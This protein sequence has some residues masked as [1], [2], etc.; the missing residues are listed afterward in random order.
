MRELSETSRIMDGMPSLWSNFP[1]QP[2][3]Q[4]GLG[5]SLARMTSAKIPSWLGVLNAALR[6][7]AEERR[8]EADP[9]WYY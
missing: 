3:R 7:R 2:G 4:L 1:G 9:A 8:E 5:C 6:G